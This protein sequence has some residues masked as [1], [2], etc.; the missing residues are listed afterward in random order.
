MKLLDRI[1]GKKE[2]GTP[3]WVLAKEANLIDMVPGLIGTNLDNGIEISYTWLD[4]TKHRFING[5]D[6]YIGIKGETGRPIY[7]H[8]MGELFGEGLTKEMIDTFNKSLIEQGGKPLPCISSEYYQSITASNIG[9]QM[10]ETLE[11]YREGGEFPWKWVLIIVG[12][13]IVGIVLWQT[14]I[15]DSLFDSLRAARVEDI[16][17]G[18]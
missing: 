8:N 12:I 3:C 17:E 16:V 2:K 7:T 11:K 18:P 15:L 14:G 1:F 13:I 10:I 6:C 5:Q 9:S 4:K